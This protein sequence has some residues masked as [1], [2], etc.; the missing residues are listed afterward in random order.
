MASDG[1]EISHLQ[2]AQIH[3]DG[4]RCDL[5]Y[6]Q[7][8]GYAFTTS[9]EGYFVDSEDVGPDASGGTAE[10]FRIDVEDQLGRKWKGFKEED[11]GPWCDSCSWNLQGRRTANPNQG[12]GRAE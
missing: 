3:S 11:I 4:N 8:C 2:G 1:R 6:C 10:V 7:G 9:L 5:E 12:G